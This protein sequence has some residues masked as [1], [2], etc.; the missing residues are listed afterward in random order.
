MVQTRGRANTIPVADDVL[1]KNECYHRQ[2]KRLYACRHDM[3]CL[4][5]FTVIPHWLLEIGTQI[6]PQKDIE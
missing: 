4:F 6:I 1:G 5:P 2:Y 3:R